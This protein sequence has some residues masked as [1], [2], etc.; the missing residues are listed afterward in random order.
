MCHAATAFLFFPHANPHADPLIDPFP[1][2]FPLSDM[3]SH[4]FFPRSLFLMTSPLLFV[5]ND[6]TPFTPHSRRSLEQRLISFFS[7]FPL[8]LRLSAFQS[9]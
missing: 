3:F 7:S 9:N 5:I 6:V 4:T 2:C 8:S 1:L